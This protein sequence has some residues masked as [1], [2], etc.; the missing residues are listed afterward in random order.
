MAGVPSEQIEKREQEDPDDVHEMPVEAAHLDDVVVLRRDLPSERAEPE[1]SQE[2]DPDDQVKRVDPG[3]REV[4]DEEQLGVSG[5]RAVHPEA[6]AG[7]QTFDNLEVVLRELDRQERR[8]QEHRRRQEP[9]E[10]AVLPLL[11]RMDRERHEETARQQDRRVHGAQHDL[12]VVARRVEVRDVGVTELDEAENRAAEEDHLRAEED[13]HPEHGRLPLVLEAVELLRERGGGGPHASGPPRATGTSTGLP[14]PPAA[15]RSCAW[16]AATASST[17]GS[18]RPTDRLR[19]S[20]RTSATRSGRRE[21][22]GIPR[23]GSTRPPTRARGRPGIPARRRGTGG[24]SRGTPS[25]T[26]GRT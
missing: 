1:E 22:A 17:P 25:R 4:A 11:G 15:P 20:A 23:P 8:P 18:S 13:P 24:S 21:A 7:D 2:G 6:R 9:E 26:G 3:H 16:A 10:A 19:P 12:R 14:S 5:I